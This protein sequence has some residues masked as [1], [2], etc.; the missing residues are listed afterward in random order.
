MP[1]LFLFVEGNV[2]R[3]TWGEQ[4]LEFKIRAIDLLNEIGVKRA[5]GLEVRV[6][7]DALNPE[8]VK[9]MEDLGMVERTPPARRGLPIAV[10]A[11]PSGRAVLDDIT[12]R[13][14][15]AATHAQ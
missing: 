11:S 15:A 1:G 2:L 9:Q 8:L 10:H 3:K 13:V 5:K 4:N 6:S 12:P 14:L 7:T